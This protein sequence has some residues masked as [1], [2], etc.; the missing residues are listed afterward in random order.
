VLF[1]IGNFIV[2]GDPTC[3]LESP[4]HFNLAVT[5]VILGYAYLGVPI[6]LFTSLC[7]C[8]PLVLLMYMVVSR[9]EGQR[10]LRRVHPI[11]LIKDILDVLE[12]V[13]FNSL[14]F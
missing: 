9:N 2:L 1:V 3:G 7:L 14:T 12:K 6:I 11:T 13:R 10:P 5:F 8:L 4:I